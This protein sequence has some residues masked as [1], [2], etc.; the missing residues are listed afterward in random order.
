[1]QNPWGFESEAVQEEAPTT[2]GA[3]LELLERQVELLVAVAT[4]GRPSTP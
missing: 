3:T 1:M 2:P 4:G